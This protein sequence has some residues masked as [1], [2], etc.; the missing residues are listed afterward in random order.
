[1]PASA[2]TA[3]RPDP[4]NAQARVPALSYESSFARYRRL[5]DDKALS[6][7]DANDTVMRIGGWRAYAREAQDPVSVG[8]AASTATPLKPAGTDSDAVKPMP[9]PMPQGHTGHKS[10]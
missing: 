7:R 5:S 9:M 10:P 3:A 1:M 4:L 8:P 6:W 2:A